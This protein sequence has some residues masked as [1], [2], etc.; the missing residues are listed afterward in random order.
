MSQSGGRVSRHQGTSGSV[1]LRLLPLPRIVLRK[2]YY[3][4]NRHSYAD[5]VGFFGAVFPN[6]DILADN[7]SLYS[8]LL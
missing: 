5:L 4:E 2:S 8:S 3:D 1:P 7:F 6:S